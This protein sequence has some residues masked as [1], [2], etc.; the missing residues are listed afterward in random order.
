M[1]II[2]RWLEDPFGYF[3]SLLPLIPAILPALILHEVAHGYTAYRLGDPTAKY[4]GRLSLNPLRHLDLWGTICMFVIG[5]GWAKPVPVDTRFFKHKRRDIFLVSI[6]GIT[7]NLIMF[8]LGCVMMYAMVFAAQSAVPADMWIAEGLITETTASTTYY[9][10]HSHLLLYAYGMGDVLIN[11][12]LGKVWGFVFEVVVR[13]TTMNLCLAVF[14]LI[15][16]PP[17]DGYRLVNTLLP[18]GSPFTSQ[19]IAQICQGIMM[20]LVF[21]GVL[22][23]GISFVVEHVL[24]GVGALVSAIAGY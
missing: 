2:S 22:G 18:N 5:L 11:P 20:I 14:N 4:M 24:D 13:F 6:A 10:P 19:R 15:P 21:T 3:L 23:D 16:M 8:L 7:A 17:L 1:S 9:I 12:Y